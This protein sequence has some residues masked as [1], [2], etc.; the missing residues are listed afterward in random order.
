MNRF[1]IIFQRMGDAETVVMK[2]GY[3]DE[4]MAE[5]RAIREDSE[6]VQAMLRLTREASQEN[7]CACFTSS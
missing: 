7:P 4:N 3:E 2:D 5:I 6:E 1:E